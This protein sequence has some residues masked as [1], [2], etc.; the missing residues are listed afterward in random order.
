MGSGL[1]YWLACASVIRSELARLESLGRVV[2]TYLFI[3]SVECTLTNGTSI[4]LVILSAYRLE[5]VALLG[6]AATIYVVL[7]SCASH[8]P[9]TASINLY[10]GHRATSETP[11]ARGKPQCNRKL[12]ICDERRPRDAN[13]QKE[14]YPLRRLWYEGSRI[15]GNRTPRMFT[16]DDRLLLYIPKISNWIRVWHHKSLHK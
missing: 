2:T 13:G 6:N 9:V 10:W 4:S 16:D 15:E 8:S 1:S 5:H 11:K 12:C 14:V 3:S 7:D